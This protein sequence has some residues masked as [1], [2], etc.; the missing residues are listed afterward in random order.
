MILKKDCRVSG[1][2]FLHYRIFR[3]LIAQNLQGGRLRRSRQVY[4]FTACGKETYI[5]MLE[6]KKRF[7][8]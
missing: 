1:D 5:K 4:S 6:W 8:L 7:A 2:P 3:F